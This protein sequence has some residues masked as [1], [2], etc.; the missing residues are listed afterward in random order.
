MHDTRPPHVLRLP[1]VWYRVATGFGSGTM[2]RAPGTWG[3]LMGWLLFQPIAYAFNTDWEM[4]LVMLISFILMTF[5]AD[6]EGRRL[7]V[8]DHGSIVCDEIWAIWL[9]LW[10]IPTTFTWQLAGVVLFRVFDIVKPAPIRHFDQT[11]KNGFGVMFDDVLAAGYTLLVLGIVY[12]VMR[13]THWF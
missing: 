10:L 13:Y 11:W 12:Q 6:T 3:T 4:A 9:V 5:A 2:R 7:G 8:C 1:K